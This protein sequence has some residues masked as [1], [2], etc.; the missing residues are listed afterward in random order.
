MSDAEGIIVLIGR[1]LIVI[2]PAYISGYGFHVRNPK[3]AEGYARA[4]GFPIVA[5]AGIPA[6]VWLITSSVSIA[7]G[8]WPDLGALMLGA[9][10]I[11]TALYFHRFWTLEDVEQRQT[12]T[13]FFFRNVILLGGCL[14]MFGF[15]TA[16]GEG[17]RYTLTAP[18]FDL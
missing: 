12:Q 8:I 4:M 17:L 18:L 9:F 2:F 11:P 16:A 5:L 1:I 13:G 10:T 6:G 15:F 7:L 3:A 14:V